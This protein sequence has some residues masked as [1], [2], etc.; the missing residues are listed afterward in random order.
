M[1]I[2]IKKLYLII[3]YLFVYNFLGSGVSSAATY[4]N[5]VTTEHQNKNK[6]K[7]NKKHHAFIV[8][9]DGN[10]IKENIK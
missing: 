8:I 7:E 6:T 9:L 4:N 5:G 10:K 3:V 2:N 1:V